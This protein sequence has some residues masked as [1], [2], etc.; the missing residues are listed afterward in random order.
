LPKRVHQ[1]IQK[2]F[3]QAID[4]VQ[5]RGNVSPIVTKEGRE[6]EIEWYDKTLKDAKGQT[7][8][9]LSIG[10][11]VTERKE[12]EE[13]LQETL[14]GIERF[15]KLMIGRESRVIEMKKEV[16]TLLAEL[17]REPQYADIPGSE[18]LG[19]L[20]DKGKEGCDLLGISI[21]NT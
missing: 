9:L 6:L 21:S 19:L 4:D 8:G 20:S 17:G 12:N 14:V 18:K 13:K 1:R 5:T 2:L 10:Q 16:N 15:N 7:I 11:D 3:L